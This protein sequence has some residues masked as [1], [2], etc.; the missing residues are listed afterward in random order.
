MERK[1]KEQRGSRRWASA[2]IGRGNTRRWHKV[3]DAGTLRAGHAKETREE[4]ERE[5]QDELEVQV[6]CATV[7][8]S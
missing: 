8:V 7:R 6:V 2:I 3:A 5:R 1:E 4:S